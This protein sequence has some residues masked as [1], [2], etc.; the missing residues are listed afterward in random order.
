MTLW[1]A[2]NDNIID[3]AKKTNEMVSKTKANQNKEHT[4]VTKIF[5]QLPTFI[6]GFLTTVCSY[7]AQNAG[8]GIKMLNVKYY[9]D[10]TLIYSLKLMPSDMSSLPISA[11]LV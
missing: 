11:P 5:M 8:I 1:E 9:V 10:I 3:I 6:L 7:L 4:E 2:Q